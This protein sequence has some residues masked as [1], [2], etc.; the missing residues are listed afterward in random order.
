MT[1][2]STT[3]P[4]NGALDR[5]WRSA[6]LWTVHDLRLSMERRRKLSLP[7]LCRLFEYHW[8]TTNPG[9]EAVQVGTEAGRAFLRSIYPLY[10]PFWQRA[11]V[12]NGNGG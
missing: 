11:H 6:V 10:A 8:R 1:R 5:R 12:T 9:R 7:N 4:S 3:L 2:L